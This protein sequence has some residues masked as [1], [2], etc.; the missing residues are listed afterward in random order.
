MKAEAHK[1]VQQFSIF[2]SYRQDQ[3]RKEMEKLL[4]E[5]KKLLEEMD[6]LLSQTSPSVMQMEMNLKKTKAV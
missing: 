5:T 4:N 1:S 2:L 3:D 6:R